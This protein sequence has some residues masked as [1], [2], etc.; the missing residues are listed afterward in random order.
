MS[1][2]LACDCVQGYAQRKYENLADYLREKTGLTVQVVWSE[3]LFTAL[4][5]QAKTVQ[6]MIC[7]DSVVRSDAKEA[8]RNLLPIAIEM[9]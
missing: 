4:K 9:V 3:S 8:K 1:A 7:K 6:F 5:S 2:P